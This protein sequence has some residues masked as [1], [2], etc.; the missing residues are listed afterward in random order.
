MN[1]KIPRFESRIIF[2]LRRDVARGMWRITAASCHVEA[3]GEVGLVTPK[4]LAKSE[5]EGARPPQ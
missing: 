3:F 4:P 2:A 5:A 1:A